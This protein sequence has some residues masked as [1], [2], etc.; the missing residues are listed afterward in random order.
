[1]TDSELQ[2]IV[3]KARDAKHGGFGVLSTGEKL[4]AALVLNRP[5]WLAE[6]HYTLAEAIERVGPEWLALIPKAARELE[7]EDER[8][9][10]KA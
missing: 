4:A 8:A 5:D 9:A 2:H 10:G 3:T 1:M 6:M 7:Y